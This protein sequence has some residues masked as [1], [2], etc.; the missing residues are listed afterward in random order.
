MSVELYEYLISE[1]INID[2][3][4]DTVYKLF[5]DYII[6]VKDWTFKRY[7]RSNPKK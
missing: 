4:S 1:S 2:M 3:N 7:S 5:S 6:Q